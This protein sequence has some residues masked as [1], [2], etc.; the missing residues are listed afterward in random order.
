MPVL[1]KRMKIRPHPGRILLAVWL[2]VIFC[3]GGC[4]PAVLPPRPLTLVHLND[5]HSHLESS[6]VSLHI[7]RQTSTVRLGGFPR[8]KTF[9]DRLRAADPELLL[10]H[11]G[12]AV[13]GTLYFSRF[14]GEVDFDFLNL[15]GI[16]ALT[17]GNHEFDL[18]T[19]P[20]AG[21]IRRSRFP[22]LA[23]NIDFS[24]EP[25][26]APLVKPFLIREIHGEKVGIIGLTTSD[27]P[28]MTGDVGRAVFQD[29][30]AAARREVARLSALGIN[31][32][33]VLSHLGYRADLDLAVQVA[34]IDIIV[35]GHSHSLLADR[36]KLRDIGGLTVTGP[37]PT[38]VTAPD[39]NKVL[40]LQAW[41]WGHALGMVEV[42]FNAAGAVTA[43]RG[44]VTIPVGDSF[45]RNMTPIPADS[46]DHRRI[47]QALGKTGIL[48]IIPED[49]DMLARL[50]PYAREI[51]AYRNKAVATAREDLVRG[52]NSGPGPL[53]ADSM[54]AAFPR[55]Q[56]ALLNCGG[57]RRD[58]PAGTISVGDIMEVLPFRNSLVLMELTGAEL[59]AAL[60]E[61]IA[62][63]L[64][65]HPER[66]P[67]PLPYIAGAAFSVNL[68]APAGR[69]VF[70]L[71]ITDAQ[72]VHRPVE[73]GAVYRT[74]VNSFMAGGGDGLQ[75]LK[76]TGGLRIDTGILDQ[77]AFGRHLKRLGSFGNPSE[78][79]VKVVFDAGGGDF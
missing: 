64:R 50:T 47:V 6:P 34:G 55:T 71:S 17:F 16:D 2:L 38:E 59:L 63:T 14:K 13:Q 8:I 35:G 24:R 49:R 25:E 5:T 75:T 42:S 54:L 57:V 28:L 68:N 48:R 31:R 18:G 20:I 79:R 67:P 69:R 32:I 12:D 56:I 61:H 9:L 44:E 26:I 15:L 21:W 19:G 43:Y 70:D 46:D 30:K 29:V 22:W 27:T 74:V 52:I 1:Q 78:Q 37:Y 73:P 77:E 40:V 65:R 41:E 7:D 45:I 62:F 4:R 11:G 76:N 33:I 39:G 60:E 51:S 58:L 53:A 36:E 66:K 23:A 10:L 3:A 72:G